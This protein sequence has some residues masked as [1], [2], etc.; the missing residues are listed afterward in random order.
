MSTRPFAAVEA[1]ARRVPCP[2]CGAEPLEGCWPGPGPC[3]IRVAAAYRAGDVTEEEIASVFSGLAAF[4]ASTAVSP[5]V[6]T[7]AAA[8]GSEAA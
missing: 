3:L 7:G 5:A 2:G 4:T 8:A 1:A 6:F